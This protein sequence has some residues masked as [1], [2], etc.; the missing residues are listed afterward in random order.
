[1]KTNWERNKPIIEPDEKTFSAIVESYRPESS[2][3][4]I[5]L[6]KG[7]LSHSNYKLDFQ[8][9]SS[10]VA[11]FTTNKK[12]LT[13]EQNLNQILPKEVR[14]PKFLHL[15]HRP[16]FSVALVEWKEGKLLRDRLTSSPNEMYAI[17]YSV[18]DQ[19]ASLRKLSFDSQ[20]FLDANVTVKEPF[21]LT[22][23]SFIGIIESFVQNGPMTSRI[24][25]SLTHRIL[26][27]AKKHAALFLEDESEARLV[28]GDFNGLNLLIEGTEVSAVLDWE[29]AFSGSI[30]LD[31]G[32]MI[33]Y[34]HFPNMESFEEGL[35]TG[36]KNNSIVLSPN[37][38]QL[39]KLADLVALCSL[40][41][42]PFGGKNRFKDITRLIENTLQPY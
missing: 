41:D 22:P 37:W 31:I 16:E 39:A 28:H 15:S 33:R 17:G 26:A 42:S 3:T 27:Y 24:S 2:I 5:H 18:G 11:R 6:L 8:D 21:C 32:N 14:T 40:L 23:K 20:G 4:N 25:Q 13:L 29:F 12:T 38:R 30:Y 7:G 9:G 10:L 36:L 35:L 34:D 19:L 1:M